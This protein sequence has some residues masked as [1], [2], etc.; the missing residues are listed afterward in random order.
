LAVGTLAIFVPIGAESTT[1]HRVRYLNR[2][3]GRAARLH[4]LFDQAGSILRCGGRRRTCGVGGA[5]G[6]HRRR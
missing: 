3:T 2:T 6:G 1:C 4:E 5:P